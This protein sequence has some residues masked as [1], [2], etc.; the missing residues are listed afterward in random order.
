[1]MMTII[2]N[3]KHEN[4]DNDDGNNNNKKESGSQRLVHM[5]KLFNARCSQQMQ[6]VYQL[7]NCAHE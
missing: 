1:M 5:Q 2:V 7:L 4:N 3:V 6:W